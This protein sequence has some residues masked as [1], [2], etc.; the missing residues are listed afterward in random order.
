MALSTLTGKYKERAESGVSTTK[1]RPL[2][3][4]KA[5]IYSSWAITNKLVSFRST[6]YMGLNTGPKKLN[7]TGN[8]DPL[9]VTLQE[10]CP[11]LNEDNGGL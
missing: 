7:S 2:H 11:I 4:F 8:L 6:H 9:L 5:A 10:P 3:I 1:L